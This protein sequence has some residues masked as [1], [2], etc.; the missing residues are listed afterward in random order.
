M[1]KCIMIRGGQQN[2]SAA[3]AV[4]HPKGERSGTQAHEK[5]VQPRQ[6]HCSAHHSICSAN[7]LTLRLDLT[8]SNMQGTSLKIF[9]GCLAHLS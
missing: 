5:E 6:A 1:N 2:A 3:V 8:Q 4:A 7:R 9:T